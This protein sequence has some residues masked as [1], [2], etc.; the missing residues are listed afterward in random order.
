MQARVHEPVDIA[1]KGRST[2]TNPFMVRIDGP[3]RGP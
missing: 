2:G 3:V 1:I